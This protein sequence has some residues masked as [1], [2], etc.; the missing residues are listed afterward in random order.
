MRNNS[1]KTHDH[2]VHSDLI[3][4]SSLLQTR[5]G[6]FPGASCFNFPQKR[7][8][9]RHARAGSGLGV[10]FTISALDGR[11]VL[12]ENYSCSCQSSVFTLSLTEVREGESIQER[13]SAIYFIF[14]SC[15]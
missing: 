7:Y 8:E 3:L 6:W 12:D 13:R 14:T 1:V 5:T 15:S 9:E 2:S 4:L 11:D 10:L